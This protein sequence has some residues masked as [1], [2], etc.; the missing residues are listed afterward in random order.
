MLLESQQKKASAL[1]II[2]FENDFKINKRSTTLHVLSKDKERAI[3][4]ERALDSD[5]QQLVASYEVYDEILDVSTEKKT[6]SIYSED[7]YED[8]PHVSQTPPPLPPRQHSHCSKPIESPSS[9]REEDIFDLVDREFNKSYDDPWSAAKILRNLQREE[10]KI[11][12][13]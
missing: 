13:K 1:Y 8:G 9:V 4:M 2:L 11:L 12:Q 10:Q 7:E 5:D 6:E 3:S